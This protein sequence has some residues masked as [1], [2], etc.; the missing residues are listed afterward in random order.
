MADST[1]SNRKNGLTWLI[2]ELDACVGAID[3][4]KIRTLLAEANL[5]MAEVLPHIEERA[6]GYARSCVVRREN[7]EVLVL[8][9]RPNQGSVAH[10][11]SGSLCGLKVV[12]GRLVERLYEAGPDG[13]V[14]ETIVSRHGVGGIR[15]DPGIVVHSLANDSLDEV[16]ITVHIYSP[17]LSEIRRYAIADSPPPKLL[18]RS[19]TAGTKVIAIVGGGFTG[20]MTFAN[21]LRFGS[22]SDT[23][24]HII[25][26]D[27]QP[28]V[29]EG[30]AY[31]TVDGRHLLNVP[32]NRMSAWA[33]KPDDF[34]LYAQKRNPETCPGDFLPR[35]MYGA[36]LRETMLKA[37]ES[38]AGNLSATMHHDEVSRL[39]RS[40]SQGWTIETTGG[41]SIQADLVVIAVGHRPPKDPFASAWEGPRGRF[42]AD[43]WASLVLSQIGPGEPVLLLGS[44]LT[45]VDVILTLSRPDRTVPL[46]AISRR[47]LMPMTH[48]TGQP[49]P[50]NVSGL[51]AGWLSA[52]HELTV[53]EITAELRSVIASSQ[54][55]GIDWRQVL[56]A[57]RP[58]IPM[59]WARLAP[60]QR[61]RFIRHLRA[62]WEVHRHRMAP[63]IGEKISGLRAAGILEV[64]AGTL[65]SAKVSEDE[66]DVIYSPRGKSLAQVLRV[67]WIINC[68]GPGAH[69]RQETHPFLR[70]LL[71]A[72]ILANDELCLG[73]LTDELGRALSESGNPHEDVFVA[74]TLRKPNLW[75]STAVPELRAQAQIVAR[76]A[77]NTFAKIRKQNNPVD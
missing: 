47:G 40:S 42:I 4:C 25:L 66:I 65:V 35:K 67:S 62:F 41:R 58:S 1:V 63:A 68:T 50:V 60:Q 51:I 73:L 46:I 57:I 34:V 3:A 2:R 6:E 59:L 39:A 18:T 5:D 72:G 13:Q 32:A 70:P 15:V 36:Y 28:A 53:R 10:D 44:G 49:P 16:L 30:I 29:G 11:H 7:L 17:P 52:D 76:E 64:A 21:I 74:G 48:L 71:D 33:D 23:P 14:R 22:Q 56:D 77:L 19:R 43:P 20:L 27:R 12:Q 45:A 26:I 24:L 8:T 31:R 54:A 75:E 38:A 69:N 61:S 55:S 37:A 9:W